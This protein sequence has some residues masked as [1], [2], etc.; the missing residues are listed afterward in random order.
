MVAFPGCK[1]NLGLHIL[2]RRP[3]GFHDIHTCFFPLPWSDILEFLPARSFRFEC[4]GLEIP[5]PSTENLS[6]KAYH[7][8]REDFNLP[9][10]QG[11]LHKIVPM[12]AGLGGGSADAAHTLKT[13]AALFSLELTTQ[14]LAS[15]AQRLGSDCAYFLLDSP[16]VGSG[17]GEI[18]RPL[19]LS[20][21]GYFLVL[22]TPKVHV[23]TAEAYRGVVPKSPGE[24]LLS[25][26][27]RPVTEWRDILTND[28][29]LSVFARYPELAKIKEQLYSQGAVYA[30][31]SG[32]G[33]S[34][35]GLFRQE[36]S[37]KE[38]F[39]GGSGWSGWL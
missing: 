12:G 4:T 34:I 20:L 35:F 32:S 24:N 37:S 1:I 25:T 23:S 29:E 38:L 10:V 22:V 3:D 15:Y 13:I 31:M 19:H 39:P 21:S 2:N 33:S 6:V 11:H 27:E 14:Q 5:G 7:L 36:V 26:L 9:P 16:A 8:L 30:S 18:L 28:F 17:R